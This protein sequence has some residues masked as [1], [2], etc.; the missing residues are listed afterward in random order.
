MG[1]K[2]QHTAAKRQQ[3]TARTQKTRKN[4]KK[5][6]KSHNKQPK[7]VLTTASTPKSA[8]TNKTQQE[9]TLTRPKHRHLRQKPEEVRPKI[10]RKEMKTHFSRFLR[11]QVSANHAE[12]ISTNGYCTPNRIQHL[13]TVDQSHRAQS[14]KHVFLAAFWTAELNELPGWKIFATSRS[15]YF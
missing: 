10:P 14:P 6:R 3:K 5:S 11:N 4:H 12:G 8:N 9:P 2:R 7:T 13:V 15:F 1:A